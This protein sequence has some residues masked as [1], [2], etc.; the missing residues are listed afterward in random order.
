MNELVQR[1]LGELNNNPALRSQPLVKILAESTTKSIELGEN[2][3]HIYNGLKSGLVSINESLNDSN[4]TAVIQHLDTVA[5]TPEAKVEKIAKAV[6]LSS[7]ID[8]IK[9]SNAYANPIVKT[10][11][12]SFNDTLNR[13]ALDFTLC[14]SFI[15]TFSQYGYDS[16]IK[17]AVE[18][19]N[20]YLSE[21]QSTLAVL[22]TIYRMDSMGSPIYAGVSSD[23]KNMLITESY[24]ADVVKVKYGTSVP[25]VTELVNTLSIIESANTGNF[26]LGEGN[27]DTKVNNLIT[28][29]LKTA[30]GLLLYTDNR[31]LSIRESKGLLGNESKVHVDGAF[32]IADVDPNYVRTTYGNF[33]DV[34]EAYATLGFAKSEDGL[35][36]ESKSIRNFTLGFKLN[37]EKGVDLYINNTK[38]GTPASVNVSE[39]L[40][41]EPNITKAKVAKIVENTN[42]LF[43]FEFIKEITNE[44]I[45][46]EA[47]LVKLNDSYF[48]CEKV[49]SA[50]RVWNQVNEF[51]LYEFFK[52]KFG[53][54]VSPIFKTKIEESVAGLKKIEESKKIILT[55]IAKLEGSVTKLTEAVNVSGI[56]VSEI[57]KLESIKESIEATINKLKQDYIALDL[58]KKK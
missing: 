15:K 4:L 12:N 39:A 36:V 6:N 7:K 2:P 53:Y 54:D 28:P 23:L 3:A 11:V 16:V 35:G 13:G 41:L 40:A 56:E 26:T 52:N 8:A 31:F 38:I 21:N 44:R 49:N 19:V 46:S 29:A 58:S 22:N 51:E 17:T 25:L 20:T 33:Y 55:D 27:Y 9:E 43:N 10:K 18:Q 30:D 47:T 57:K 32:K 24:S 34:C 1:I 37:E 45:L 42:S 48:I 14:E 50:D 5:K